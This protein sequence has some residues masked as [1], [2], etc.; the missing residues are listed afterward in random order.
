M[1]F[2]LMA[3]CLALSLISSHRLTDPCPFRDL[4]LDWT[5]D[6]RLETDPDFLL[7]KMYVGISNCFGGNHLLASK[8]LRVRQEETDIATNRDLVWDWVESKDS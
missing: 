8:V 5:L 1:K 2:L 3:L 6:L 7:H 4:R